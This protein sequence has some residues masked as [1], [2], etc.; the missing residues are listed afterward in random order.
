MY[1]LVHVLVPA[2][3]SLLQAELDRSLAPFKRGGEEDFPIE[4]LAFDDWTP[5][6]EKVWRAALELDRT[7]QGVSFGADTATYALDVVA[8]HRFLDERRTDRW[9]GR[10]ID[11]EPDFTAY[12]HR[13]TDAP[14]DT[15]T[16]RFGRWLNPLGR[17]DWGELGGRFDGCVAGEMREVRDDGLITSGFSV[18]RRALGRLGAALAEATNSGLPDA[19]VEIEANVEL[20]STVL[21]RLRSDPEPRWPTTI[22]RPVGSAAD[23]A[24]WIETDFLQ[25][26]PVQTRLSL[27]LDPGAS[28]AASVVA[29]L[30][31]HRDA[32]VAGVAY[33]C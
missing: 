1:G 15:R 17:W 21:R 12:A 8:M 10:L 25:P 3:F 2:G 9:R 28:H 4:A 19:Q 7:G 5:L 31:T 18:G 13:F 22:V 27:A 24:R 23:E 14:L 16:G 32:V 6:L 30:E 26:P 33:H 29:A 20:A 11:V